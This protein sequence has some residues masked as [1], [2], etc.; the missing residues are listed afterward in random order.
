FARV[1]AHD[2]QRLASDRAGAAQQGNALHAPTAPTAVSA[3]R[4]STASGAHSNRLSIRS[5]RPPGPG[6]NTP[7]SF[8]PVCRLIKDSIR[9]PTI[10]PIAITRPKPP[11]TSGEIPSS[12]PT[13]RPTIAGATRPASAPSTDLFGLTAGA[14]RVRPIARPT[15]NALLSHTQLS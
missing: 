9:S 6:I 1:P 15:K 10:V 2:I 13:I 7:E 11:S 14:S 5:R 12:A 4:Y 8:T 3:R